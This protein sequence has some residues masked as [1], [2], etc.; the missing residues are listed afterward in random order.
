MRHY[1]R[2]LP[3]NAY[4]ADGS[5]RSRCAYQS[6]IVTQPVVRTQTARPRVVRQTVYPREPGGTPGRPVVE[7]DRARLSA[8]ARAQA[9]ASAPSP[10]AR[11]ARSSAPRSVVEPRRFT[12]RRSG[13][14]ACRF[15]APHLH[16]TARLQVRRAAPSLRRVCRF[17]ASALPLTARLQVRSAV[18]RCRGARRSARGEGGAKAPPLRSREATGSSPGATGARCNADALASHLCTACRFAAPHLR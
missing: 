5:R 6:D 18:P 4:A 17:A 2:R 16:W 3:P 15:A 8:A 11:R 9:Q 13:G 7:E 14:R 12:R 10:A 1:A